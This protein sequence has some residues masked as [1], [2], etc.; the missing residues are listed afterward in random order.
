MGSGYVTSNPAYQLVDHIIWDFD[1]HH[2][3]LSSI[4]FELSIELLD[5]GAFLTVGSTCS[6]V[7][8][9]AMSFGLVYFFFQTLQPIL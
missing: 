9:I 7:T 5:A 6:M 3:L 1:F 4:R 8:P 2:V